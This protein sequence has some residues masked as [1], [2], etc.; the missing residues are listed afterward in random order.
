MLLPTRTSPET[1]QPPHDEDRAHGNDDPTL[2]AYPLGGNDDRTSRRHDIGLRDA[3]TRSWNGTLRARAWWLYLLGMAA[4]TAAYVSAHFMGPHWHWLNSGLV[5]NVIGGSALFA[6]IVGTKINSAPRR[7]PWYLFAIGQALFVTGDALAYNY[8]R[9]FGSALPFPS[10]A[11]PFYLAFYPLLVAG[12]LL[13]IR[14]RSEARDR[15]SLIDALIVTVAVA[16]LSWIY[17]MAPYAHDHT[18]TL[19]TKLTSIAYPMMDILVLGVLLRMAVGSTRRSRAFWLLVSGTAVLLAT[20]AIYGWKLL[21]GGYDTGGV[22]DAGWAAFYAL[23]GAAALHPSMRQLSARVADPDGRLNPRRLVLLSAA[24][25]AAPVVMFV[26]GVLGEP[27]DVYVLAAAAIVMFALVIMRMAGIVRGHEEAL[28]REAALRKAGETL[29]TAYT[30][31][32]IYSAALDGAQAMLDENAPARLYL[33][34]DDSTDALVAVG[35]TAGDLDSVTPLRLSELAVPAAHGEPE[36]RCVLTLQ[37]GEETLCLSPLFIRDELIGALAVLPEGGALKRAVEESLATLASEVALALQSAALIEEKLNQ[38]SEARLGAL[39]K[40]ASDVICIVGRNTVVSYL[41][42][43]VEQTFGHQPEALIGLPLTDLLHSDDAVRV[44][45]F[46]AAVAAQPP[47]QSLMA[48]FRLSHTV[49]GWRDVEALGANLLEEDSVSGI[50]LNIR[51]IS[52]R[53]SL[54]A[55]LEH[56]AFHDTLTGLPNR[57]LFRNRVEHALG[58]QLRSEQSVAVLFLDIDDFKTVNDSLGHAAGDRVLQEV[59][60]RLE[61]CMRSTDTAA[62]LGGDEFAILIN[63][64][65]SEASAIEVTQRVMSAL[66]TTVP[67]DDRE[68]TVRTSIGIAYSDCERLTC[69]DAEELLRNADAAMYMAK[70]S[71]KNDYQVFEPEMHAK[72]LAR[73]ELKSDLQR[74]VDAGEFTLRYQP[75]VD[76]SQG[77]M[78][79]MEALVRWEHPTR[80]TVAPL[81]FIPLVESTGMI[82]QLGRFI[83]EE[84]CS[85]AAHMQRECPREPPISVAVNVSAFQVERRE[86]VEEV[87][88][89][90][91]QTGIPPASLILELTESVMMRDMDMST[92]HMNSLRALGVRLAIDDFGTGYS[93]LNYLRRFPVDILKIDRSFLADSNPEVVELTAA[94]VQL[95]QIFKLKAVAEGIETAGQLERVEG[96]NCEF[97][98]GFHFAKPL[99]GE[100]ILAL[101]LE[102]VNGAPTALGTSPPAA[103]QRG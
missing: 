36:E 72:A 67:L 54:Q 55:E 35:S 51:D 5:Y 9:I 57:A 14:E 89:V 26:R 39:I 60:R 20:D 50:V 94:V 61:S 103:P 102:Q 23:L 3:D 30:R 43:S 49:H 99:T 53:K 52:E 87:R 93:S 48:E 80:G 38:R 65:E 98:Q 47:G 40:N 15:A 74:A 10:I 84:A 97:G 31:E 1:I 32:Q 25:F 2:D 76:L 45:T 37:A 29:V 79:C 24:S 77:E 68:V 59:G 34:E 73:L 86:F 6:L 56:Q 75:I 27:L 46:L 41:S 12:M 81:D 69:R 13:L 28:G 71:G 58:G 96:T 100:E 17:L 83:L 95:A 66:A 16:A 21:H 62:R 88:E 91:E 63:D 42:P 19:L 85:W 101:A 78:T 90:L 18:L 4:L 33:H 22:L 82:V 11:D 44:A 70:E 7:L 8:E 64:S 92:M